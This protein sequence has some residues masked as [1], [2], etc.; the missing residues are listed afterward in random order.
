MLKIRFFG[1]ARLMAGYLA[2]GLVGFLLVAVI[3]LVMVLNGRPDLSVWHLAD[4]DEEFTKDSDVTNFEQYLALEDRLF[5]QLDELVYAQVPQG[6]ANA[7]NRYSRG[8][9]S[10]PGIWPVNW[11]RSFVL[12]Q[13]EPKIGVLLLHGLSDSPYSL[14]ALGQRLHGEGA[15]VL[16]LRIPGHGTVPSGLIETRWQDMAAAVR[17]AARH[18]RDSI[19]DKPL[20][21][22][23][24]SNGGALAVEY[25]LASL[26][27]TSL[28]QV[29][30]VILLSPEIGISSAA[31][32][33]VWQGR[34]GHLLGLE[35]L[36][37]NSLLPE[38]DPFKY[39]SFTVNAGDLAHRIT[40]HIQGQ[41][42][43]LQGSQELAGMPPV[44]AFQSGVDATVTASALVENLFNRLPP[45]K[46]ELV[47]F[48]INR[49]VEIGSLLKQDPRDVFLPILNDK[50]RGLDL[51]VVTNEDG[52]A[53]RA[54]AR[55]TARGEHAPSRST[56]VGE[57]PSE[58][59]SLSHIALPFSPYDP[60]YGG[61]QATSSPG[62]QLGNLAL[63][64]E[65]DV[66]LVSGTEV[67]RLHW[68]PF[69]EYVEGRVLRFT[70]LEDL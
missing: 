24:Y 45:A 35:K 2:A 68:N 19:G 53:S 32:L 12:L 30:G 5:R 49:R 57:W 36:A 33:A 66:L 4:L 17:L 60:V 26:R 28:P 52:S 62:I 13:E 22:V 61:P 14:R 31:A 70:G 37:W 55:T 44:L 56:Y 7:I 43:T 41:L 67:M 1:L 39:G 10:D 6:P 64:G 16:G 15:M 63:R 18:L 54:V 59:Y 23:G 47:L 27:E 34:L 58:V 38:Y 65:R 8:S 21:L 29:S 9:L 3:A 11:N 42:D 40:L 48:D 25:V 20:F 50:N 51:T 46:H 69:Y